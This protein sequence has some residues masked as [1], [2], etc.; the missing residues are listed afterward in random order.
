MQ[1]KKSCPLYPQKR[2]YAM[3]LRT[4]A[5][6]QKRT[7]MRSLRFDEARASHCQQVNVER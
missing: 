1:R 5:K 6:G 4:S 2:T 7:F 3:Q